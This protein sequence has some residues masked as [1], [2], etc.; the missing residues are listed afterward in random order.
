VQ[1]R[2]EK[3]KTREPPRARSLESL[4]A[5]PK[6]KKKRPRET[7]GATCAAVG[8][9]QKRR[10]PKA[11]AALPLL[12]LVFFWRAF[13]SMESARSAHYLS[14]NRAAYGADPTKNPLFLSSRR[15]FFPSMLL[16]LRTRC[17]RD[18]SLFIFGEA[19]TR[20]K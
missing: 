1:T 12:S 5:K 10:P 3:K 15:S 20:S 4:F 11:R 9:N 19:L 2:E 18:F 13:C 6:E 14:S 8:S 7:H 16:P 17:L